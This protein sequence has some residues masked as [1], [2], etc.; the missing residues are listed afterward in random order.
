MTVFAPA[1]GYPAQQ[2]QKS[3]VRD[4]LEVVVLALAL[5]IIINFAVQTIHVMGPSMQ[6][7]LQNNDFLVASKISYHLHDPQRGDIIVFKPS[8]DAS[9]DYIKRIIAVPGDHLRIA[10]AQI[11]INGHRLAEPYL[12]EPWTWS[13]TWN[14]GNE[15]VV[16]ANSYFVMG[17][18][19][20][21]STDSRFLGYQKKDQF[22]GK[23]WVRIWPLSEFRIFQ[24]QSEFA[25]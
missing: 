19:R 12:P 21:H 11:F 25:T 22:L 9:H 3:F 1:S 17:D 23:A 14:Q 16:P 24:P 7:T 5:Y 18:N 15:D 8:N 2:K 20:N 13:D 10:H 6:N 4:L